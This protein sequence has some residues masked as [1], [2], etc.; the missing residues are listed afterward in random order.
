MNI[1]KV[2]AFALSAAMLI[3]TTACGG[4]AAKQNNEDETVKLKYYMFGSPNALQGSADVY[5]EANKIIK[6]KINAEVDFTIINGGQYDQKMAVLMASGEKFDLMFTSSWMNDYASNVTK[7]AL[8]EL[9]DLLPK[10]AKE[11]YEQIPAEIWDAVRIN[12]KIYGAINEQIMARQSAFVFRNDML[13]KTGF[14]PKNIKKF[15]D[16]DEYFTALEKAGV[17]KTD[18]D[19]TGSSFSWQ[20]TVPQSLAWEPIN[21]SNIPGCVDDKTPDN[22]KV[23][24]QFKTDEFKEYIKYMTKWK[25]MGIFHMDSLTQGKS[26][27]KPTIVKAEG[28]YIP[29]TWKQAASTT[30]FQGN[31]DLSIQ[32]YGEVYLQPGYVTATLTGVYKKSEHPEK[33]VEFLNLVNTNKELY[34]LLTAGLEGR[35]YKKIDENHIEVNEDSQYTP[36]ADWAYGNQFNAYLTEG[37]PDDAWEQQRE[38]NKNSKKSP[39]LGFNFDTKNVQTEIANCSAISSEYLTIAQYGMM[40]ID[41]K[42]NE[43]IKKLDDAGADKIIAEMQRQIDEF[44]KNKK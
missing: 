40:D 13:E 38:Y 39:L 24:N 35:D 44:L 32:P 25:D 27:G 37:T 17:S 6:E 21:S 22:L 33:A 16:I 7:G 41:G 23:F 4:N 12:G 15:S 11:Y 29:V 42:Y 2:L 9:D 5:K 8:L 10:Y 36:N 28:T 26:S 18:Y 43:F 20:Y 30:Q 3:S 19:Y 31:T 34:R 1:K 14:D